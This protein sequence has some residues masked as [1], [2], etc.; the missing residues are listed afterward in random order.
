LQYTHRETATVD[1]K[2]QFLLPYQVSKQGPFIAK[3]DVTGDGLE[4]VFIGGNNLQPGGLFFQ[5]LMEALCRRPCNHGNMHRVPKTVAWFF[6]DADGDKD[7][8]LYL[9]RSSE[10]AVGDAAFRTNYI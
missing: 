4:D 3:G 9:V 7:L 5:S 10:A 2:S 1:F 8:D 6:F